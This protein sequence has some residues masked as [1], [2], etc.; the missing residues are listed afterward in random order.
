MAS[1]IQD[2]IN[3][4]G[5]ELDYFERQLKQLQAQLANPVPNTPGQR[6]FLESQIAKAQANIAAI[7]AVL[8]DLEEKLSKQLAAGSA[9]S[10]A[11]TTAQAAVAQDD[12]A[13]TGSAPVSQMVAVDPGGRVIPAASVS[14]AP[15]NAIPP[16]TTAN[17][18][19]DVGTNAEPVT[20]TNSQAIPAVT[21]AT[22]PALRQ[23]P[24]TKSFNQP[25]VATNT[26]GQPG[27]GDGRA[28]AAKPPTPSNTTTGRLEELYAGAQNAIVSQ[29]NVLDQFASYTYSLSWYLLDHTTYNTL[30]TSDVKYLP[31]YNLLV[32]SGGI[33]LQTSGKPGENQQAQAAAS[34]GRNPFFPLDFYLDNLEFNSAISGTTGSRG[35][36]KLSDLKFTVTEPNGISL[37]PNLIRAVNE[38]YVSKGYVK[39]G[40]SVNY[41]LVQYCMVIRF[42]GY[43]AQGNLVMPI[44]QRGGQ[45]D[46]QA[47]IEKFIPFQIVNIDFKVANKLVEYTITGVPI[48]QVTAFSTDR[49]SIP[50]NFQFQGKSVKDILVGTSQRVFTSTDLGRG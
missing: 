33:Q 23:E 40:T 43:D 48:E 31:N 21:T 44:N 30:L 25:P 36:A 38:L 19:V 24:V 27:V 16:K 26:G 28:D 10:S 4:K 13:K 34:V 6:A 45:T 1:S 5:A 47:A 39:P 32:Q 41:N 22:T 46:R 2:Q 42:Y 9:S 12:G 15:T 35:S 3:R 11:D 37:Q 8:A 29:D 20:L 18:N 17:G 7:E 49:G 50:Q 14:T